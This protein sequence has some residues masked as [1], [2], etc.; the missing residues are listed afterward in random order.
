MVGLALIPGC[1]WAGVL[2]GLPESIGRNMVGCQR[3][4][5][6]IEGRHAAPHA[7]HAEVQEYMDGMLVAAEELCHR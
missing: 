4:A 1:K 2:D 6:G 5:Q 7:A 3:F